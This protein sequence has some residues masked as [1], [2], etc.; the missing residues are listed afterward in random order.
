MSNRKYRL[1]K[2]LPE[3]KAGTI[4]TWSEK[5]KVY[6]YQSDYDTGQD[7]Y[8]QSSV[9]ENNPEWFE[10]VKEP[11]APA[12]IEVDHLHNIGVTG[13]GV[14]YK[15]YTNREIKYEH[16]PAVS[17][18]IEAVVNGDSRVISVIVA[19]YHGRPQPSDY[20]KE[21]RKYAQNYGTV[22]ILCEEC[23]EIG[24]HKESCS[25]FEPK[26]QWTDELV[27][28][29]LQD[30]SKMFKGKMIW[31]REDE[32]RLI[33]IFKS[34]SGGQSKQPGA[35]RSSTSVDDQLTTSND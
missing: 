7:S 13:M 28:G 3:T 32:D 24:K 33:E 22:N 6:T 12:R 19:G 21:V 30:F 26:F 18:A 11:E 23:G 27:R 31:R 20:E 16:F 15:F 29:I 1:L 2:D 17:R 25:Q 5:E 8:Y 35:G 10:E 9:V 34:K 4:L 14:N